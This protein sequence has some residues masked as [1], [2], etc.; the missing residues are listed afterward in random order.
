MLTAVL[1]LVSWKT[2]ALEPPIANGREISAW[3][4]LIGKFLCENAIRSLIL[5]LSYSI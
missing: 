5:L 3:Q 4:R 2:D 1:E